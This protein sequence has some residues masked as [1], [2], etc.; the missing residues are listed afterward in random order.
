[1]S[2]YTRNLPELIPSG[3]AAQARTATAALLTFSAPTVAAATSVTGAATAPTATFSAP[4][5]TAAPGVVTRTAAA[6]VVT[7]SAPTVTEVSGS[8]TRTATAPTVTVSAPVATALAGPVTAAAG[9]PV[10]T[11]SAPGVAV[12]LSTN[13]TA[14]APTLTFS[15][16]VAGTPGNVTVNIGVS[17]LM[18]LVAPTVFALFHV[19][20]PAVVSG[21]SRRE[22]RRRYSRVYPVQQIGPWYI[23]RAGLVPGF[24]P[25]PDAALYPTQTIDGAAGAAGRVF[26]GGAI[27]PATTYPLQMIG[28]RWQLVPSFSMSFVSA[29]NR[30]LEDLADLMVLLLIE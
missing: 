16:P 3:A 8:A 7:F 26:A 23:L 12:H 22:P 27:Y 14:T 4:T 20:Q 11:F 1:M 10:A 24:E 9:V 15:A 19:E 13:A 29:R 6:P 28:P 18:T 30:D 25:G 17:A 5:V 2:W 21:Y